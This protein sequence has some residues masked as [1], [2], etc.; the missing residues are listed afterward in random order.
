MRKIFLIFIFS[1]LLN[2]IWENLHS[3]LYA[4]YMGREITEFILLRASVADAIIITLLS[5]PF[6][7]IPGLRKK[8]RI[9]IFVGG[10]I[11]IFIE[12]YALRTGRWSYN[13]YMPIIPYLSV[14]LTPTIQL[15]LLGYLT[16]WFVAR[17]NKQQPD[18][19]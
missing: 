1:F 9:I 10:L 7:F 5:L 8:G 3:N 17:R 14:G 2:F 12:L 6:V 4:S 19:L 15:G 13:E 11:A 18:S 16:Y